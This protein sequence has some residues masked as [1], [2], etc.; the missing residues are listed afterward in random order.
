MR[1]LQFLLMTLAVSLAMPAM[2]SSLTLDAAT[3]LVDKY[4]A[5]MGGRERWAEARSEYV[6]AVVKDPARE[7]PYTFE[8]CWDLVSPRMAERA[9]F[10]SRLQLRAYDG[11]SGWTFGRTY[12]ADS[13]L[14]RTW[15]EE[16]QHAAEG[17]WL[18]GFEVVTRAL[19]ARDPSI[20]VRMGEGP[21][22][23]WLEIRHQDTAIGMLLI[24]EEGSPRRYRR[25]ADDTA[26]MFGPL[27]E[28]GGLKFPLWGAFE[29]GASFE[30]IT[31]E[32]L[33]SD[34]QR[35]FQAPSPDHDGSLTCL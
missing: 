4:L 25:L 21:W 9:R 17:R 34:P 33:P 6:L 22:K 19:A 13:G 26:L 31:I 16:E 24:D 3:G 1:I 7:L 32:L 35:P 2:S 27:V 11:R 18:G 28:R 10:Q 15:T 14:L 30:I 12:E 8:L 20:S 5:A 29:I 23:D